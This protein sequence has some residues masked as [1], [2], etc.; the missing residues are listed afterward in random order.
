MSL[1]FNVVFSS[2]CTSTHHKLALDALRHLRTSQ[3]PAWRNLFLKHHSSYLL[4]AKAPDDRFKD[5]KNHVLHVLDDYWGGAVEAT[6]LWYGRLVEALRRQEWLDAVY[7]AGVLSHYYTDPLMPLHTGQTEE[8]GAVHR[9][10]E[11]SINQSYNDFIVILERDLG[12]YPEVEVPASED[13]LAEMVRQ[14]AEKSNPHYKLIIDHYDIHRGVKNPP[15]GLDDELRRCMAELVGVAAVGFARILERAFAE[16]GV[17]P[18]DVTVT[19]QGF[20]A[21]LTMPI[22][23][24]TRRLANSRERAVVEAMYAELQQTGRVL[25]TLPEDDRMVRELHAREVLDVSLASLNERIPRA[26]GTRHGTN[27]ADSGLAS[28]SRN[29]SRFVGATVPIHKPGAV[30]S[31][32]N[33]AAGPVAT[34]VTKPVME[35]RRPVSASPAVAHAAHA[36]PP[37]PKG[38]KFF[39]QLGSLVVDAPSIGAKTADRLRSI[40]IHTVADLLAVS[41]EDGATRLALGRVKADTIR[42]WQA[43]AKLVCRIPQIR[44]HDAQILVACG[45]TEPEQLKQ[46][47]PDQVLDAVDLFVTSR[48][49]ERLLRDIDP[50]NIDEVTRWVEWSQ[51]ARPLRAA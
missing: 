20:L 5:F 46:M 19:L 18:P 40:G 27:D 17:A 10:A 34:P 47:Q 8:E 48:E 38:L 50:P 25:H 7:A 36:N 15:A 11:W 33:T 9:A 16:S 37:A 21:A 39:L 44:G 35:P 23:W 43:Q 14:A 12:G 49:G 31:V 28:A 30:P 45:I 1:L 13:W 42:D 3:A 26:T 6:R 32:G 24:L 29:E 51:H 22:K 4:G 2:G 41:P